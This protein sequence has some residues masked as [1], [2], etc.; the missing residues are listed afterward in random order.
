MWRTRKRMPSAI[1]FII[2]TIIV[3]VHGD[4]SD[5]GRSKQ[6]Y[7]NPE[8]VRWPRT[9]SGIP[10][11]TWYEVCTLG[12]Y[13]SSVSLS[14]KSIK[15]SNSMYCTVYSVQCTGHT[16]PDF[17]FPFSILLRLYYSNIFF[18]HYLKITICY[19][20]IHSR[21]ISSNDLSYDYSN[22]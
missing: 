10:D 18:V 17:S 19:T 2:L 1:Y 12:W 13:Y 7:K 22:I 4:S 3:Q 6:Y 20:K 8:A 21:D 14:R 5:G 15:L 16:S 9:V 11:Y